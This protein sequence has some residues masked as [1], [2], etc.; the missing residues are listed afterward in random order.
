MKVLSLRK[1]DR[2]S[3]SDPPPDHRQWQQAD[4]YAFQALHTRLAWMLRLSVITN[5]SL[6]AA[7][8]AGAGAFATL[9]PL[10]EV[11]P[12][13]IRTSDAEDR[14]YRVEPLEKTVKG[15]D[16]AMEAMA[17]RYLILLLEID[18][19]SQKAR[20]NEAFGMTDRAYYERFKAERLDSKEIDKALDSGLER[21]IV[22]ASASKLVNPVQEKKGIYTYAVNFTQIDSRKGVDIERKDLTAYLS[23]TTAPNSAT[24]SEL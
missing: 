9:L 17:K 1:A 20:F 13:F 5:I 2:I 21:R 4:P 18:K 14:V 23:M 24:A 6:A 12:M 10:K 19:A 16:L 8:V 22:I 7:L 3:P 15:F 11:R